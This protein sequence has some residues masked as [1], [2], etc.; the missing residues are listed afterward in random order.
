M[1]LAKRL[2][3]LLLCLAAPLS[4]SAAS[5]LPL[6]L[7]EMADTAATAFEG[8]VTANRTERDAATKL[9][10][11]YTTFEVVDVL[12]GAVGAKHEIKQIG[13]S[14]PGENLEYRVQGVPSFSTGETYIV[15]LAGISPIGFSSPI[16]LSQGRFGVQWHANGRRVANGRDFRDMTARIKDKL[17]PAAK[18]QDG[19]PVRD[20][21]IDDFKRTVRA[22]LESKR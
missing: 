17:P 16:G 15:F 3:V 22:H 20:M 4:A 21:D 13:G 14:L 10:V 9:V 6:Y 5:V 19:E 8:R 2:A 18:L 7:D 12:K 11:T 1:K